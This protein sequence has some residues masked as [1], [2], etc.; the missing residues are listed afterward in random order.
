MLYTEAL[1]VNIIGP[2]LCAITAGG[3]GFKYVKEA[4][5]W[6]DVVAPTDKVTP[7]ETVV[8]AEE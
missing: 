2:A 6:K 7:S 1:P 8:V 3:L 4:V 5:T